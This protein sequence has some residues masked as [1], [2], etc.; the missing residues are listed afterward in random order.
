M[1]FCAE[2]YVS[3]FSRTGGSITDL[4]R[5]SELLERL[6]NPQS[7]QKFVHIAG[8]N[9]KGSTLEY[10]SRILID[11][12]Y[13]TGQFT[14]PFIEKYSDRIRING[15]NIRDDELNRIAER[16]KNNL[17]DCQYSQFE[18]TFSIALIYFKEK[19]CDIV[20]LETGIGGLLDATNIIEAP[21]V[22]VITSISLDHTN[23]LGNTI[24]EVAEQKAGIIKKRCPVVMSAD[25]TDDAVNTVKSRADQ[26]GSIFIMP[27]PGKCT[28]PNYNAYKNSFSETA[29]IY[30]G[31]EYKVNM[32]GVHQ[33]SNG[34]TAIETAKLLRDLGFE[35]SDENIKNGLSAAMV[36]LRAEILSE[37]P[38]VIADGAHNISGI[39]S[40][41]RLLKKIERP[42]I[43]VVGMVK[44]KAAEYAGEKLS[45]VFDTVICTD[46]F[47]DNNLSAKELARN[48]I[49]PCEA[50]DYR[51]AVKKAVDLSEKNNAAVVMCGSL[52][53]A[54][55]ARKVFFK[56]YR[57]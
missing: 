41:I 42:I 2:E 25:N 20:F 12:G 34:M 26:L 14:S 15:E 44:G 11:A 46:G 38:L 53:F 35:I 27:E 23:I 19:N 43:G 57:S 49:C 28:I 7:G 4:S 21:L 54:S 30:K 37:D 31:K 8:T 36:K 5:I 52:Y 24:L 55:A 47:I 40:L 9:G 29:F 45:E 51:T 39:D 6:G 13:K 17:S 16:V 18:I 22:S 32:C 1:L 50:M 48:F 56:E 3:G 33:V 10:I